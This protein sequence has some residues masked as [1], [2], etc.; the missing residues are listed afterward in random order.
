MDPELQHWEFASRSHISR[1]VYQ[2]GYLMSRIPDPS[3]FVVAAL[4]LVLWDYGARFRLYVGR[5]RLHM[6]LQV[7]TF[8]DEVGRRAFVFL[9]VAYWYSPPARALLGNY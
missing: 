8:E 3:C 5:S 9:M 2:S 4:A 7:L 1:R 6:L